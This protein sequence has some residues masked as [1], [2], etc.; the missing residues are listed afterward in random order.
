MAEVRKHSSAPHQEHMQRRRSASEKPSSILRQSTGTTSPLTKALSFNPGGGAKITRKSV[1]KSFA[2]LLAEATSFR[3]RSSGTPEH[4]SGGA[5]EDKPVSR[6]SSSVRGHVNKFAIA[7]NFRKLAGATQGPL[8]APNAAVGPQNPLQVVDGLSV[9]WDGNGLAYPHR[10]GFSAHSQ[11]S[12]SSPMHSPCHSVFN[13]DINSRQ[14]LRKWS[15][16]SVYKWLV[17]VLFVQFLPQVSLYLPLLREANRVL[18]YRDIPPWAKMM[19]AYFVSML[20]EH[21][22]SQTL[23]AKEEADPKPYGL[24]HDIYARAS[25][26]SSKIGGGVLASLFAASQLENAAFFDNPSV[27][28]LLKEHSLDYVYNNIYFLPSSLENVSLEDS[29][30]NSSPSNRGNSPGIPPPGG[31]ASVGSSS[32]ASPNLGPRGGG[33]GGAAANPNFRVG[34]PLRPHTAPGGPKQ[35]RDLRPTPR[36]PLDRA[37]ARTVVL[38]KSGN[39]VVLPHSSNRC[40]MSNGCMV[41]NS[42]IKRIRLQHTR[43]FGELPSSPAGTVTRFLP[44]SSS[45][46]L[47]HLHA[48]FHVTP[49]RISGASP[50]Y[51]VRIS[52]HSV[53]C[54]CVERCAEDV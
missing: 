23:Q 1:R 46:H 31:G 7:S 33:V 39:V 53:L 6:V 37:R 30:T 19:A 5:S 12:V 48:S 25:A 45:S 3:D 36:S 20:S 11:T 27:G 13:Q 34:S 10:N 50:A 26:V 29:M 42:L 35:Q 41:G 24:L 51:L 8:A 21:I 40:T 38:T 49:R 32:P 43:L 17:Y 47:L 16:L 9:S 28:L 22:S 52:C 54:K 44:K 18:G 2:A 15:P 14:Q 4:S